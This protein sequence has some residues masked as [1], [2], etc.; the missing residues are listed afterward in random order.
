MDLREYKVPPMF[1]YCDF[2]ET[3]MPD[4][5]LLAAAGKPIVLNNGNVIF[6]RDWSASEREDFREANNLVFRS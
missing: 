4:G 6:P 2:S 5:T 1:S 3:T